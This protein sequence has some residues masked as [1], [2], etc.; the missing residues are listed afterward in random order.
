MTGGAGLMVEPFTVKGYAK[1]DS[2]LIR[3][4]MNSISEQRL[5]LIET[6]NQS[7]LT[8]LKFDCIEIQRVSIMVMHLFAKQAM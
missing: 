8:M 7:L 5:K 3:S 1:S 6:R 4:W 2:V